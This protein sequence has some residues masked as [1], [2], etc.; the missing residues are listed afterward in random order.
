M[1]NYINALIYRVTVLFYRVRLFIQNIFHLTKGYQPNPFIL[2]GDSIRVC[3]DRFASIDS[4]VPN[5]PLSC[6]DIGC[7]EGFFT[8]K[9]AERG[10]F[11][12]GIDSGRNEVMVAESIKEIN[13]IE[14]V[15]FVN[16]Q[17]SP[18][19]FKSLPSFD[20][21]FLLSVFHHI[22]RH[23]DIEY[24]KKFMIELSMRNHKYL[25]F[26]TGQPDEEGV[27]WTKD[28]FFMLP[29]PEVWIK[30]MLLSVGYSSVKVIGKNK[31]IR[32]SIPRLLFLATK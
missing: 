1:R 8:F 20:I 9:M 31:S 25:V 32:S 28:L 3:Q 4:E 16:M 19:S 12:M 15:S 27:D 26:E 11:C 24:A 6:L 30:N 23:N 21:I 29:D 13:R 5:E 2:D 14:N 22:V 10:G 7:N 17:I 18:D